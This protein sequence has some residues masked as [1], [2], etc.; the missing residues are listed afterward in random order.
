[1]SISRSSI[2][3]PPP[4]AYF[5][6][7][8]VTYDFSSTIQLALRLHP[9]PRRLVL[10]TGTSVTDHLWESELRAD[11]ARL[12]ARPTVE[13]LA[14]LPTDAVVKRLGELGDGD[15]VFTPGYFSDGAGRTFAPR[16]S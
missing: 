6:R 5:V 2:T 16:D 9:N 1:M 3:P 11:L 15:V 12:E 8:P 4:P 7:G 14:G 10:V 13:F